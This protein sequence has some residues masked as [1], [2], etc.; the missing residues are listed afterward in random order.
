M[1][2]KEIDYYFRFLDYLYNLKENQGD[3]WIKIDGMYDRDPNNP[4]KNILFDNAIIRAEEDGLIRTKESIIRDG[5]I[6]LWVNSFS[7]PTF[8]DKIQYCI[9]SEYYELIPKLKERG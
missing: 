1:T 2:L 9:D 4:E 8:E 7:K 5:D 3:V 6:L